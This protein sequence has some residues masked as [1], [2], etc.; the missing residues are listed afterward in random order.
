M[1]DIPASSRRRPPWITLI[2]GYLIITGFFGTLAMPLGL[3]NPFSAIEITREYFFGDIHWTAWKIPCTCFWQCL[4]QI[5]S[6]AAGTLLWVRPHRVKQV[7]YGI[8]FVIL[9]GAMLTLIARLRHFQISTADY[10]KWRYGLAYVFSIPPHF[11]VPIYAIWFVR[12]TNE[13]R[14]PTA[15]LLAAYLIIVGVADTVGTILHLSGAGQAVL[16]SR[17]QWYGWSRSSGDLLRLIE[18][19]AV[20]PAAIVFLACGSYLIKRPARIRNVAWPIFVATLLAK[21]PLV[22]QV[23]TGRRHFGLTQALASRPTAQMLT[24]LAGLCPSFS[25]CAVALFVVI[26]AY[27]YHAQ[28]EDRYP[29]CQVCTY[30]LTGNVSGVCP[31]CGTRIQE[32]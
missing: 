17:L 18:S 28:D 24:D 4:T 25:A 15:A 23:A 2:A 27:R 26:F 7:V 3:S 9:V 16:P 5:V 1:Q 6:L 12:H 19:R 14:R 31:E 32:Q 8:A 22:L 13:L 21:L 11:V 20:L 29:A 30:N 10:S